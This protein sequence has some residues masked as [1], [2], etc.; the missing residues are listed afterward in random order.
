MNLFSACVEAA[1][2]KAKSLLWPFQRAVW[3]KLFV[4]FVLTGS[5]GTGFNKIPTNFS[6]D[7]DKKVSA[8]ANETPPKAS[9]VEKINE[10]KTKLKAGYQ[11]IRPY[12]WLVI[13]G[14]VVLALLFLLLSTWIASRLQVVCIKSLSEGVIEIR[15][16]WR[17]TAPL[18]QALFV[19]N[20]WISVVT[21]LI[22]VPLVGLSIWGLYRG[23]K[24]SLKGLALLSGGGIAL[25]FFIS[26]IAAIILWF[27]Q[28]F[29]PIVMVKFNEG[30][31]MSVRRLW[32][33]VRNKP[34]DTFLTLFLYG[35]LAIG[36][37]IGVMMIGGIVALVV[38]IPSVVIGATLYIL[39]KSLIFRAILVGLA[40]VVFGIILVFFWIL[41]SVPTGTFFTYLRME[42]IER[43]F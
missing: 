26:I 1:F 24:E 22:L 10:I 7:T 13:A 33:W 25:I 27:L 43:K 18:G 5:G 42:L 11:K 4:L 21:L 19:F 12:L 34:G 38:G 15:R 2:Q 29:L 37:S 31:G 35:V 28:R 32:N 41:L 40:T 36:V 20:L 9:P 8:P 30:P 23:I 17:E 39:V 6:P 14:L 3:L 16:H